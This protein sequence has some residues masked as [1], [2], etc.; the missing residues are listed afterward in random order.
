MQSNNTSIR[1]SAELLNII[2]Q[3][4]R[5][6]N[7]D[8]STTHK[9]NVFRKYANNY[10]NRDEP[11]LRL[12]A[13]VNDDLIK[14]NITSS[15][16]VKFKESNNTTNTKQT[17]LLKTS[18]PYEDNDAELGFFALLG[19]LS[20]RKITG[21][22]AKQ[23]VL[24]FIKMYPDNEQTIL[25]VIDKDL[26]IRFTA[27]G[28]NKIVPGL[29]SVFEVSLGQPYDDNTK[30]ELSATYAKGWFISRKLDGVR[31]ICM[32]SPSGTTYDIKFYS[33]QGNEFD[34]L[35]KVSDDILSSNFLGV[36]K[37]TKYEKGVVLDG[38]LC[39]LNEQSKDDFQGI[40][41]EINKKNH[42]V[43]NPKYLLFDMLTTEEFKSLTS[44]RVLSERL[45]DLNA[46]VPKSGC[47]R[48]TCIEQI[49]YSQ[50]SF[51]QLQKQVELNGWEG[52]ILRK[53]TEYQGKRSSDILKVK[54]F[55]REEYKVEDMA[56]SKM[57]VINDKTGLE[58]EIETLKSVTIRHKGFPVDVG[59]GFTLSERKDF[60]KNPEKIKGK[61]ISVQYFEE[62]KDKKGN[63]SLRF[64][65]FL[66]VHGNKRD[67]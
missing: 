46:I 17:K 8:N 2:S 18:S 54:K 48:L 34:T 10:N 59:S 42:T 62:T 25:N 26:K 19:D 14:F 63:I 44:K 57:R 4:V 61:T 64:P 9:G 20:N 13:L 22:A 55:F 36:L 5:D 24:E 11:F 65:T 52:L 30:D 47:K 23:H 67:T 33:R 38:E 27:T 7:S 15:S 43:S 45:E 35:K 56:F 28:M 16:I 21:N 41:K 58:E 49:K 37:G 31:C 1:S 29:I 51:E 6:M 3:F 50:D 53:N 66:C 39:V 40:M 32:I 12:I 60:Y